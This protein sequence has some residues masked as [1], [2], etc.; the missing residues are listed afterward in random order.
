MNSE[1]RRPAV[2]G[3]SETALY[4]EDVQTAAD[5]YERVFGFRIMT[6][7]RR[8]SALSICKGQALLLIRK[9]G[10]LRPIVDAGGTIPPTDAN[11]NLHLAFSIAKV[12]FEMWESWLEK[13][14]VTIYS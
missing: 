13:N 6:C 12:E 1:E 10:S 5:F 4:V 9:G 3:I 14:G 7:G 8:M 11:G 2:H